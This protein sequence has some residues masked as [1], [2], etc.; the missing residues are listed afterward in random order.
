VPEATCLTPSDLLYPRQG[1]RHPYYIVTPPHSP[2]SA[3]VKMLHLVCHLINLLGGEAFL[4]ITPYFRSSSDLIPRL[5]T[6]LLTHEVLSEHRAQGRAGIVVVSETVHHRPLRGGLPVRYVLNFT[7]LLGGPKAFGS[8][9]VLIA[10][11]E[12]IAQSLPRCTGVL[13]VPGSDPDYFTPPPPG[14]P[15]SGAL[16]Y[17]GKY[18]DVHGQALPPA[19]TARATVLGRG[20]NGPSR[21]ELR[22]WFRKSEV[23]YIFENTALATEAILCGCAVV[24]MRN[25]FFDCMIAEAELGSA[26]LT[27]T[28]SPEA[29]AQ[30]QAQCMAFR[31]H[32]R[33]CEAKAIEAVRH[34]IDVTQA[35]VQRRAVLPPVELDEP[36]QFVRRY[37]GFVRVG[38]QLIRSIAEQGLG[39]TASGIGRNLQRKAA[40][41]FTR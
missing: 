14:T 34:L 41:I 5:A 31:A 23:L 27:W 18:V 19:L 24:A 4:H 38:R 10:Y 30:A 12:V 17:A 7:G 37:D 15:R 33:Q 35:E 13:F 2:D 20:P 36:R 22:G 26:G 8:D 1:Q 11:S 9:E 40:A 6:P 28:D 16:V 21:E 25:P 32:Y 29:I 39:A 3:G